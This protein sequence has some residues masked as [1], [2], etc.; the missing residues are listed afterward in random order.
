MRYR[1]GCGRP[2]SV[3]RPAAAAGHL[4]ASKIFSSPA[5]GCFIALPA[6]RTRAAGTGRGCPCRVGRRRVLRRPRRDAAALAGLPASDGRAA[7]FVFGAPGIPARGRGT[8]RC[9][10]PVRGRAPSPVGAAAMRAG[11]L[12]ATCGKSR[13]PA[14][15][16]APAPPAGLVR[17]RWQDGRNGCSSRSIASELALS[18]LAVGSHLQNAVSNLG[19]TRR[20]ELALVLRCSPTP[21]PGHPGHLPHQRETSSVRPVQPAR[22]HT[23][24]RVCPDTQV[25][26]HRAGEMSNDCSSCLRGAPPITVR[27]RA[28]R[29]LA[30]PE[31]RRSMSVQPQHQNNSRALVSRGSADRRRVGA[32]AYYLGRPA[33]LWISITSPEARVT[34]PDSRRT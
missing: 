20:D 31:R 21:G 11:Q 3:S 23:D 1:P 8:C 5:P 18:V 33:S 9:S 19:V 26:N 32:P 16:S 2:L 29:R 12:A 27:E 7:G 22:L 30:S 25:S 15:S 4:A 28:D 24:R 6:W 17:G 14:L 34:N 10:L 13:A